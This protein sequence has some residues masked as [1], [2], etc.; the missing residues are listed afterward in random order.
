MKRLLAMSIAAALIAV[1]ARD[2]PPSPDSL[3]GR[4]IERVEKTYGAEFGYKAPV[5]EV[6]LVQH[7]VPGT[8]GKG[9]P[10]YVVLHSAGHDA[11]SALL[12]TRT[13]N[14]HDI[15]RAPDDFYALYLDCRM[16]TS[17]DWWWGSNHNG[18]LALSPCERRL[19]ATIEE[20][21]VKYSID[22]DRI[23][24]SGNSMGGSG[25]LGLGLRH[26]NVFAAIKANVP[27]LVKHASSRMGW[28]MERDVDAPGVDI[29]TFPDP[30]ALVDYSAPNDEKWSTG[31]EHLIAMMRAR[32]YPW[33]LLW[34]DFKH[35]NNDSVMLAKNDII[36]ALD[37]TNIRKCDVLPVFTNASCDDP[38]PWPD[39][40]DSPAPGQINGFFRWSDG[41]ASASSV[42]VNLFL[43]DL[44]S[45]HFTVPESAVVDVSLRRIGPFKVKCGDI[46][47]WK[48]GDRSGT[49]VVGADGLVTVHGLVIKKS[50]YV[51]IVSH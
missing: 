2:L 34:A 8:E 51:L 37:W 12:C 44:K 14:N 17:T 49:A 7:P 33:M 40:R 4:R 48:F 27:A 5:K 42:S 26:G 46:V 25:T 1:S 18:G 20:V 38:S 28:D 21:V 36:H 16:A 22:R 50:P 23:Y 9:R 45:K 35:A 29:S 43:A 10:L 24:L 6:Y 13:P 32:K 3:N 39:H 19:L 15:Y 11:V 31:H 47:S 30:P 41:K